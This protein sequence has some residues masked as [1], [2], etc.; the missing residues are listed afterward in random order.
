MWPV[1]AP[2]TGP[3]GRSTSWNH[4]MLPWPAVL[5][6]ARN[7][8]RTEGTGSFGSRRSGCGW[9]CTSAGSKGKPSEE[10]GSVTTQR[11]WLWGKSRAGWSLQLTL[12]KSSESPKQA[13]ACSSKRCVP[14][15]RS[16]E[17]WM[18]HRL[19]GNSPYFPHTK[20]HKK[21]RFITQGSKMRK[22]L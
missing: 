4:W 5:R 11:A 14:N 10:Q 17:E 9:R 21:V 20:C 19:R 13:L 22:L 18:T 7:H 12:S 2:C 15:A 6:R 16:S 8:R 3:T 1:S